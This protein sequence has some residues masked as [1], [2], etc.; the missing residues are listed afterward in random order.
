[1]ASRHLA[2]MEQVFT[3]YRERTLHAF[4]HQ[5]VAEAKADGTAVTAVD[6]ET[7]AMVLAQLKAHT[8][9]YGIVSEEEA[10]PWHPD[11]E[12]RWVVDPIDGTASFT[13]GYPVWG[14]GIGLMQGHE[15]REGYLCFP[16]LGETYTYDGREARLNGEIVR[17]Q[18][19]SGLADTE[20]YLVDSSLHKHFGGYEAFRHVKL[21]VFGSSLY[22]MVC[23]AMGRAEAMVGGRNSLWDI[24][25][26]LPLTRACGLRECYADG[27]A[28]DLAGITAAQRFRLRMPFIVAPESRLDSLVS[29]LRPAFS[30]R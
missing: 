18:P 6:R 9:D 20:N 29:A 8:P 14:L 2:F 10:E 28:L 4:R 11:A 27:S 30:G 19:A 15:P 23:V 13:R 3:A 24:A 16:A 22:H 12:W 7:S 26:A 21:R 5:V 25:A 1:M 17:L